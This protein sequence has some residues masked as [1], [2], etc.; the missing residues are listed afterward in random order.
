MGEN[1]DGKRDE[2]ERRNAKAASCFRW[3][4]SQFS[5][6]EKDGRCIVERGTAAIVATSRLSCSRSSNARN[7]FPGVKTHACVLSI[8]EWRLHVAQGF[9][10]ASDCKSLRLPSTLKKSFLIMKMN[11][12]Y[13]C[14][15]KFSI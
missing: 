9:E 13:I 1:G 7:I 4:M 12:Y 6:S 14:R 15:V 10:A 3:G 5:L 2:R 8:A 11:I